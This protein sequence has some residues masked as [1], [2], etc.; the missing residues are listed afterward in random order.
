MW[1]VI[2]AVGRTFEVLRA[3][4]IQTIQPMQSLELVNK[5]RRFQKKKNGCVKGALIFIPMMYERLEHFKIG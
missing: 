2:R 4:A 5:N 1:V 3:G